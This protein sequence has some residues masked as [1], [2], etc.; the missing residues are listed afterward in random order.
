MA[1]LIHVLLPLLQSSDIEISKGCLK[2][3]HLNE[4]YMPEKNKYV[5]FFSIGATNVKHAKFSKVD[6]EGIL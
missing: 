1:I 3:H 2:E 6:I 5:T 4:I